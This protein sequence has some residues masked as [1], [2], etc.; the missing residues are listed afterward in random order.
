MCRLSKIKVNSH[1][2]TSQILHSFL[3]SVHLFFLVFPSGLD[4][5]LASMPSKKSLIY[6]LGMKTSSEIF[7]GPTWKKSKLQHKINF[8]MDTG[9]CQIQYHKDAF[10]SKGKKI[11]RKGICQKQQE[12]KI[13]RE[14][15]S[16][17][18]RLKSASMCTFCS[19]P[20]NISVSLPFRSSLPH[21]H[22][23]F[24]YEV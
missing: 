13:K 10:W 11:N 3:T 2:L 18:P 5:D 4:P 22:V 14:N 15:K 12:D 6:C 19:S 9:S 1:P 21:W 17:S 16:I 8:D 23:V 20:P 24:F 7:P